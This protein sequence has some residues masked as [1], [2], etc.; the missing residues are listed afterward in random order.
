MTV[1]FIEKP[2]MAKKVANALHEGTKSEMV[3]EKGY[4][5]IIYKGENA[6]V[7]W[8]FGHMC[9]LK[10]AK[11][12]NADYAKWRN[13]PMPFIPQYEIT[14]IEDK[15]EQMKVIN[16]LF[17][18]ADLIM[19]GTDADR[20]GNLIFYYIY[21]KLGC[22]VPFVRVWNQA[23][24]DEGIRDAFEHP[25]SADKDSWLT[26]AGRARSISDW[27]VGSNLT[28]AMTLGFSTGK[29]VLSIGRVQTPTL[30]LFVDREK[31][32][33]NFRKE[34]YYVPVGEF[35]TV[36]G[37]K[38]TGEAEVRYKK[39]TEV[40]KYPASGTITEVTKETQKRGVP[41][42]YS[43]SAL[44]MAANSRF[45]LTI[46]ETLDIA[47]KLYE[48]GYTTYP[49]TDSQYLNEDMVDKVNDTLRKLSTAY[50]EYKSLLSGRKP[51]K[52]TKYHFDDSKV[53]GH[54][55]IIPT[56]NI[57]TNLGE[58][59]KKVYDLVCRSLITM[60]YG[61]AEVEKTKVVTTV[62]DTDFVTHGTTIVKP[63]WLTV[64]GVPKEKI[65]PEVNEK[66]PV[67]ATFT[68]A[69]R[70]TKPPT[71][72]DDASI[73][74]A[75]ITCGKEIKNDELRDILARTG[76]QGI[77]RESTRAAIIET[78]LKRGYIYRN[79]KQLRA[80]DTGIALIDA[81]PI[82]DIQ[83][84]VLT[85]EWEK[86]LD[87]VANGEETFESFI[88]DIENTVRVWCAD[89]NAADKN[90]GLKESLYATNSIG[91][92]PKCGL[93]VVVKNWGW[94]CTGWKKEGNGCDFGISNTICEKKL[95]ETQVKKLLDTGY[96]A[97]IKGFKGKSG[98][99][100]EAKLKIGKD[101]RVVFDF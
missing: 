37:D 51:V 48:E 94:A 50:P 64:M 35:I 54:Y 79:K 44:Q 93:P 67:T 53:T 30:K 19:N 58:N 87:K 59:E 75:M 5:R 80:T 71:P 96:T 38:Y 77:G 43:L 92:C 40:P 100:F 101:Y 7:T 6:Y 8:G 74:R 82:E 63:E 47:Q 90:T 3:K 61:P 99:T 17:K 1:M 65:V 13:L 56:G 2:D 97:K 12:Y 68:T 14:Y 52:A 85:A 29:Q 22:K 62:G 88:S 33:R 60:T 9:T 72:Y 36:R 55:A 41:H 69:E 78:L 98:K 70:E 95:T 23:A 84:P 11:D 31:A 45:G 46:Q 73:V 89:I 15:K 24:T 49:R 32:I 86:R 42:L 76:M 39:E 16:S 20:E 34:K 83:S 81:I 26:Q 21:T 18:K 66:E 27:V 28:V 4:I 57:P 10:Q 25:L 91:K